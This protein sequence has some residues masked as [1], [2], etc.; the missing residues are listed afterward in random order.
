MEKIVGLKDGTEVIIR[1]M[2]KGDL[3]RSLAFFQGLPA[4]D[5]RYLRRDVTKREVVAERIDATQSGRVKRL[6]G[7]INDEIVADGSLE[8]EAQEWKK[9]IGEIRLVVA[10]SFQRKGLGRLMARELYLLAVVGKI[11]EIVVKMMK[12]QVGA[13]GI[14]TRLGFSEDMALSEYVKDQTG[15][16]QDLIVMRCDLQALMK[17]MEDYIAE[18]DWERTR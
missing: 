9:H 17:E 4:D 3:D 13:L 8:L 7:L 2:S 10:R 14:F 18:S 1:T 5:R 16:K 12:P 6:V 15:A 11:E